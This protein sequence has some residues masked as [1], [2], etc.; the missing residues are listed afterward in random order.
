M[1]AFPHYGTVRDQLRTFNVEE[2]LYPIDEHMHGLTPWNSSSTRLAKPL[3][4]WNGYQTLGMKR[5]EW[6][7]S[8]IFGVL[9]L[10]M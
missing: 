1:S 2:Q 10:S 8:H 9:D 4:C 5:S 7:S 6:G 3:G